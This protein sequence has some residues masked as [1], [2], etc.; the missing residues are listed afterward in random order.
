[1]SLL[2]NLVAY[3]KLDESSGNA[4]DATGNGWTLTNAG[5]LTYVS[6]KINN[7]T[8]FNGSNYLQNTGTPIAAGA[9]DI[10]LAAWVNIPNTNDGNT[11]DLVKLGSADSVNGFMELQQDGNTGI[12]I[13]ARNSSGGFVS[14][15]SPASSIA[16]NTWTFV[17][18]LFTGG[19]LQLYINAS[20]IGQSS[21]SG[22][23]GG[24]TD[25]TLGGPQYVI[26]TNSLIDEAGIWNRALSSAEITQ[27]YNSGA[28]L[29]YPFSNAYVRSMSD[30]I[31][32]G[33]SRTASVS[34]LYGAK[35]TV[36]DSLMNAASRFATVSKGYA[37]NM[38]DA[39]MNGAG[40]F[41]I[42]FNILKQGWHNFKKQ[43]SVSVLL[44][45]YSIYT[46]GL[47]ISPQ[48]SQYIGKSFMNI[49]N[50]AIDKAQ[51]YLENVGNPNVSIQALLYAHSGTFGVNGIPTG[52]V[53]AR[54]DIVASTTL[55]SQTNYFEYTASSYVPT[56]SIEG[57]ALGNN[58]STGDIFWGKIFT[59]TNQM[60][61]TTA[62]FG[63]AKNGNPIGN[64]VAQIYNT[65][66]NGIPTN[67]LATSDP[68]DVSTFTSSPFFPFG[69]SNVTFSF[70]GT[71]QV[72]MLAGTTYAV[73]VFYNAGDSS[74]QIMVSADL[75]GG[76]NYTRYHINTTDP[77]DNGWLTNNPNYVYGFGYK[78]T[79]ES[80]NNYGGS[81]GGRIV[82]NNQ[83]ITFPFNGVNK[84]ELLQNTS[85]FVVI[86]T[87]DILSDGINVDAGLGSTSLLSG[88]MATSMDGISWIA[89]TSFSPY[90]A[91]YGN[92]FWN[93][94]QKILQPFINNN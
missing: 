88:N 82:H 65:D 8:K 53:L 52:A 5:S 57:L 64:A 87:N 69:G 83:L 42:I 79:G 4:S 30:A 38:S 22:T 75:T 74:D 40:R 58:L 68:I 50:I 45:S 62:I 11:K 90:F 81:T 26:T 37:R 3:Y 6:G 85:Y 18:G 12:D 2:T 94:Q 66:I 13:A 43:T 67:I 34:R 16:N 36:S 28:G 56:G 31:L 48:G 77:T 78:V 7:A 89:S 71:N 23:I 59:N 60:N 44:A 41:A 91:V 54:S 92:N 21:L 86:T 15:D 29:Q 47:P 84:V 61:I 32:N 63:M 17:T 1:M 55:Q 25:V 70:S 49:N 27:L 20:F 73:G 39:I 51:F 80:L 76:T 14:F 46:V 9:T 19:H 35:R 72:T 33:A 10:T 93:N 24:A